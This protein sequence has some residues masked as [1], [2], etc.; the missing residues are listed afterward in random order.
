M[1]GGEGTQTV[2]NIVDLLS[3]SPFC[4]LLKKINNDKSYERLLCLYPFAPTFNPML[5]YSIQ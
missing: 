1:R 2:S 5:E 4:F 3:S